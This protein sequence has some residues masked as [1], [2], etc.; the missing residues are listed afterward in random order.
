M[1]KFALFLL[2]V[3]CVVQ[4]PAKYVAVLETNA[5]GSAR[6]QVSQSDRMYLTNVLREEA[7]KVLPAEQNYTIMTRENINAMLPPGKS[8]EEC[9]GSCLA[10][11]GKNI[12][13]DYVCQ[14]VIGSFAGQLTLSAELYETAGNKLVA[15]FNG[16]GN[17]MGELLELIKA[18]APDFFRKVKGGSDS[19]FG[20]G[21]IG[22]FGQAEAFSYAA[23]KKYIVEISSKPTGATPTVDGKAIPKCLK[24]P[25]K[26]QLDEGEH[27]IVMTRERYDDAEKLV[28][29]EA[30]YQKIEMT[31]SP[32]YGWLIL[33]PTV[34]SGVGARENI[35]AI[36][37][38]KNVQTG[39]LELDPGLHEVKVLHPCADPVSFK[40]A[41]QKGKTETYGKPLVRGIGGLELGAEYE[42]EP[43]VVAVRIDGKDAGSTP[44]A[45]E[46]PLCSKVELVGEDWSESVNVRLKWHQVVKVVHPLENDPDPVASDISGLDVSP[47]EDTIK[48]E[49]DWR[50]SIIDQNNGAVGQKESGIHWIPVAISAAVT[51][52]GVVLA[53]V[54]NYQA[55]A[56]YDAGFSSQGE[57]ESNKDKAHN[58][59][60]LRGVGIGVA[61]A[62]GIGLGLSFAF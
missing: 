12:S 33:N 19:F 55:K 53:I 17:D 51:V 60:T 35:T 57:Y 15:S 31:L 49:N 2:L 48:T 38:G 56:A 10:E 59:Q 28:T 5:S 9:E 43:K 18:K 16:R 46:V 22:G 8:I 23:R 36:V 20:A 26:V 40:V 11:T 44:F 4:S 39:K 27:R 7:V 45:G 13:A 21:G 3:A 37:D 24:T 42:G 6:E 1:N 14:A 61:I 47:K 58:G 54:G 62:G 52:T 29:V 32:N 25:C 41:I 30:N 34:F 50:R